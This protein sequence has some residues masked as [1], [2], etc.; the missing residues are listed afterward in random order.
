MIVSFNKYLSHIPNANI[1]Q[2]LV[3]ILFFFLFCFTVFSIYRKPKYY[4]KYI[5][6]LPLEVE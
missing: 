4:Y 3:L 1:L 5:Q 6:G 2:S